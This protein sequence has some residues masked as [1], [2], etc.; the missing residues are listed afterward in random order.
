MTSKQMDSSSHELRLLIEDAKLIITQHKESLE[1]TN[2]T[3]IKAET[4]LGKLKKTMYGFIVVAI[5]IVITFFYSYVDSRDRL[6]KIETTR[7]TTD[8]LNAKFA[9]KA[10]VIFLQNDIFDLNSSTFKEND[11]VV[12]KDV[13]TAYSRALKQFVGDITRGSSSGS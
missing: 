8:E 9:T 1:L 10:D 5:P 2:K 7:M 6:T 3:L 13:E 12:Q 4:T 11:W